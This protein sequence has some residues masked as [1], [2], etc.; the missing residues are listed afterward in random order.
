VDRQF[1]GWTDGRK[2]NGWAV[3]AFGF[4][5]AGEV[6]GVFGAGYD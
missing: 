3:P 1:R 6:A 4:A 2:W 5:L